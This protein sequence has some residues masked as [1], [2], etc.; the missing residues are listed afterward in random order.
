[1]LCAFKRPPSST[2]NPF[3]L[4]YTNE[5]LMLLMDILQ[6]QTTARWYSRRMQTLKNNTDLSVAIYGLQKK[7]MSGVC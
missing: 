7:I 6:N 4:L 1:M 3:S 5:L 2:L